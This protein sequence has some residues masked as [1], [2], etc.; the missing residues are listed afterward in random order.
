MLHEGRGELLTVSGADIVHSHQDARDDPG[1]AGGGPDRGRGGAQAVRR[2]R[3]ATARVR[4]PDA[5]SW[6]CSMRASSR[7]I[8]AL[9]AL[10]LAFQLKLLTVAGYLPHLDSCASCGSPGPLVGF[11]ADGRRGGLRSAAWARPGGFRLG[12]G[13]VGRAVEA[14]IERPLD[15][16]ARRPAGGPRRAA[17]RRGDLRAARRFPAAH[18]A[19]PAPAAVPA[20]RFR[21]R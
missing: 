10:G 2:A 9:D 4:R 20:D 6:T 8:P 16:A 11:S 1:R 14:L 15:Q 5:A 21:D 13:I 18:P 19:R 7:A 12:E 3:A 17:D